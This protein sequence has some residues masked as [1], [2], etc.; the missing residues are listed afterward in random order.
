MA[1]SKQQTNLRK[2][3]PAPT[4]KPSGPVVKQGGRGPG[5]FLHEVIVELRKTTWPTPKEAWRLTSVVL[6]VIIVVALYIGTIDFALTFLTKK[7]NLIK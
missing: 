6:G 3:T 5:Q 1:V 7:F 2:P 4:E